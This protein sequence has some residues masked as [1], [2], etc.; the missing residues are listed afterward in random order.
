MPVMLDI[1]PNERIFSM[2][3][4]GFP[5][6]RLRLL[7]A[8]LAFSLAMPYVWSQTAPG[9]DTAA[10]AAVAAVA[11]DT[12]EPPVASQAKAK[13]GNRITADPA[14]SP[15]SPDSTYEV[16]KT[17]ITGRSRGITRRES[18]FVARMPLKNLDNP[19]AYQVVPKELVERQLLTDYIGLFKNLPGASRSGTWMQ[20]GSQ[21]YTRGFVTAPNV[22]NGLSV[23]ILTDIDPVNVERLEAIRG[24]AGALFGSGN[25]IS[26]GG[27]FNSVTKTPFRDFGGSVSVSGGSFDQGRATVDLNAPLNKEKTLLLRVNAAKH[28]EGSFMDQGFTDSWTLAPT[29]VYQASDRLK[30]SLDLEIYRRTGTAVP[31]FWVNEGTVTANSVDGL[32]L[33]PFRSFTDNSIETVSRTNNVFAKAEFRLTENW[34]SETVAA[35]TKSQSNLFS[36]YLGIHDDSFATRTLDWQAWKVNTSQ[37]QQNFR[38]EFS[39]GSLRNQMLAGFGASSYNYRWPYV[40][41][42]DTVNYRNP[43]ADYYVGLEE[44]RHRVGAQPLNMWTA[45]NYNYNAYASDAL[46]IGGRFTAL[47]GIRWDRFDERGGSD[48]IGEASGRYEQDAFS[49]KLGLVYQLLKDRASVYGNILSGYRNVDGRSLDGT[50]FDPEHAYQGEAGIKAQAP[51]GRLTGNLSFYAIQVRDVVRGDPENPGFSIQN[52]SQISYGVEA[53]VAAEPVDGLDLILGYAWNRSEMTE[54][55]EDVE[56]RR[57]PDAGPELTANFWATYAFPHGSVKGLGFGLGGN[58]ASK[59]YHVNT[60]SFVFTVPAYATVDATV[61]YDQP[62]YRIGLKAENLSDERYWTPASLQ[63][64]SPRR[65]VGNVTYKF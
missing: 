59:A 6:P 21:F 47:L 52:G 37:F 14:A 55:D 20:G 58:F 2:L 45:E 7:P 35:L 49:P 13:Q 51:E 56:G 3:V 34:T 18:Q 33:D 40:L 22:R 15:G 10:V 31:N 19:Q 62:G 24:P 12:L 26:Y 39:T 60:D 9:P 28:D 43:G 65:Y 42:T 5:F 61:F 25:G 1:G 32:A 53:D 41:V 11:A 48:G 4:S 23:D 44:Y 54:S 29:L 36:I 63:V 17:M 64:G 38:G 50:T 57:P 30:L 16:G 46:H 8:V 27:L